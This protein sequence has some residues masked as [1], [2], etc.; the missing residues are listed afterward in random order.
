MSHSPLSVSKKHSCVMHSFVLS[1]GIVADIFHLNVPIEVGSLVR[2]V[3]SLLLKLRISLLNRVFKTKSEDDLHWGFSSWS[4][5]KKS[6]TLT[7]Q[8]SF[9]SHSYYQLLYSLIISFFLL[10]Q[11]V[12]IKPLGL[13]KSFRKFLP[14]IVQRDST[15]MPNWFL[16]LEPLCRFTPAGRT[17]S[18]L[19]V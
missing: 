5:L 14:T 4:V 17:G 12:S 19:S 6:A 1:H 3:T 10:P 9:H 16:P 15:R 7:S 18:L 8:T 11:V 2:F 13:G